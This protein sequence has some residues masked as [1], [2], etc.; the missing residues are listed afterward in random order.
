MEETADTRSRRNWALWL[1]P[2]LALAGLLS[3]FL[4]FSRWA[5]S[6]DFPWANLLILGVALALS[7]SG[8]QRSWQRGTWQRVG[9]VVGVGL[10]ALLS[11]LLIYYCFFLSYSLPDAGLSAELESD[12]PSLV[13]SAQDGSSIDLRAASADRLVLVFYRGFW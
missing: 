12:L 8:L 11:S 6:R 7:I 3:Y 2:P 10:S 1:G 5:T 13:L 9:G 4:L